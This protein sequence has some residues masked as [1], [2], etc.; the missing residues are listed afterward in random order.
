MNLGNY[1]YGGLV[2]TGIALFFGVRLAIGYWAARRVSSAADY[3]VA[4]RRLPLYIA[5][6]SIMATWFGAEALMGASSQAYQYGLQGVVF[7]PFGAALCLL[8]SGAFFIRLMRRARYLTVVDFFEKRYGRTMSLF[9]SLTQLVTYFAWTAAQI[10]AGGHV[11]HGLFGDRMPPLAGMITVGVIV[12]LY[13]TMG[14]MLADTLLDFI[15]MFFTAGGITVIFFYVLKACGGWSALLS[16]TPAQHVSQAFTLLPIA[17]EGF[18]GYSGWIGGCYWFAAWASLGLGSIACQDLMQ[19]SMSARNEATA[20]WGSYSAAALY[21]FFGVM[22]PLVGVMMYKLHPHFPVEQLD[23]LLVATALKYTPPVVA[24]VFVAALSSALMSTSDS[25][26]LAGASVV[27]ENILPWWRPGLSDRQKLLWTRIMV[28]VNGTM[29]IVIAVAIATIYRLATIS[30]AI[31]LVGLFAPF[32][33]GMYWKKANAAGAVAAFLGG[34]L[35][36][37]AGFF[38]FYHAE[39]QAAN[40]VEGALNLEDAVWDAVYISCTPAL[41]I[42]VALMIAVSLLTQRNHPPLPLTDVD[43]QP[44]PLEKRLGC[45]PPKGLV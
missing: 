40:T 43:G 9:G 6:A 1:E 11:L 41:L 2:L 3:I 33:F 45:L 20:V 5:A 17:G 4:G 14:G 38:Y 12:T 25:S 31:L 24:A 28:V 34:F 10:V 36:W 19:R 7:D 35:A 29:S 16:D 23:G 21:L 27:T 42:S 13:T 26:I 32:A 15:Q 37:L 22:S 8:I 30:W 18:L 39:T 44:L